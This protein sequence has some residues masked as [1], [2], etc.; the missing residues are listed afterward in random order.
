MTQGICYLLSGTKHAARLAVSLYSLRQHYAG[1]AA[2]ITAERE[3]HA[4]GETIAGDTRTNVI[5]LPVQTDDR[6]GRNWSYL[7]KT[8]IQE[9]SPFEVTAFLDGDTL[10]RGPIDELFELPTPTHIVLTRFARWKTTGRRISKRIRSWSDTHPELVEAALAFGP[11]VN[12]GVFSFSK[13]SAVFQRW[14]PMCKDGRGHFL[15]DETAMQLLLPHVPHRMLDDRFNCSVRY[16]DPD[17]PDVR[18]VHFHGSKHLPPHT[19][20]W[21]EYYRQTC[22]AD[23]GRITQWTPARDRRLK[24]HLDSL[25]RQAVQDMVP[26]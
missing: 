18:I 4:I 7:L 12:T 25:K 26:P 5:H 22:L 1:P 6:R 3:S 13:Q 8:R 2:I 14:Y 15:L 16:S 10:V 21:L 11:A 19:D 23:W 20:L 9:F 24:K 17:A